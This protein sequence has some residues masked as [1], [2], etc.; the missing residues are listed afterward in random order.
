M[1]R[2]RGV[3]IFLVSDLFAD[4]KEYGYSACMVGS[5]GGEVHFVKAVCVN[6]FHRH[7]LSIAAVPFI[8][9]YNNC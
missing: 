1:G 3:G 2:A 9:D 5:W 4:F 7:P 6:P 8:M